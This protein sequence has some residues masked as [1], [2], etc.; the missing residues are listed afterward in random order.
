MPGQKPDYKLIVKPEGSEHWNEI[1]AAWAKEKG[2]FSIRVKTP[3]GETVNCLMVK[4]DRPAAKTAKAD[5]KP[6]P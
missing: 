3:N 6:A 5:K 4:A 1:G 2:N